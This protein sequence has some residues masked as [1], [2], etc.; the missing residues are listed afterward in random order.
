MH[1]SCCV[2]T[3]PRKTVSSPEKHH[4]VPTH[5]IC[6]IDLFS[7]G[8]VQKEADTGRSRE[9]GPCLKHI[10][11]M[12]VFCNASQPNGSDDFLSLCQRQWLFGGIGAMLAVSLSVN[13]FCCVS[14][15]CRG[16]GTC[17]RKSRSQ[18]Q[19]EE[20]PIYGNIQTDGPSFREDDPPH[21]SVRDRQRT[22]PQDFYANLSLKPP[23]PQSGRSSPQI[24][25]YSDVVQLETEVAP[26]PE[27]E[28]EGNTDVVSTMSDLY[29]SVQTQRTKMF[30][31]ADTG[32]DYANHL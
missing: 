21:S 19:M 2:S 8:T 7:I 11:L 23:R 14:K 3:V 32:E 15:C 31:T 16:K 29:A 17:G 6:Y 22:K 30:V 24:Q 18:R 12:E 13:I 9:N 28:D 27:K 10:C 1:T 25:M 5:N 26:E 4:N 20:N